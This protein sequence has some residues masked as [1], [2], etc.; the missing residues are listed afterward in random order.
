MRVQN[1][2]AN[3]YPKQQNFGSITVLGEGVSK[4]SII[5]LLKDASSKVSAEKVLEEIKNLE[6]IDKLCKDDK[7]L[8]DICASE[9]KNLIKLFSGKNEIYQGCPLVAVE[10]NPI[11][12]FGRKLADA[13]CSLKS[14]F[15]DTKEISPYDV[16]I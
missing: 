14:E 12:K 1:I 4:A 16:I 15:V 13:Y 8:I 9:K 5:K 11:E 7:F 2:G 3:N 10:L 6:A